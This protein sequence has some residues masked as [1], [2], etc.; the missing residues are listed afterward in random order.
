MFLD[1]FFLAPYHGKGCCDG[2]CGH[3]KNCAKTEILNRESL[4]ME[5]TTIGTHVALATWAWEKYEGENAKTADR[6]TDEY[7]FYVNIGRGFK[8]VADGFAMSN[9]GI[10][11][12]KPL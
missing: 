10:I 1:L 5:R 7:V 8:N 2:V 12:N 9:D 4:V 11:K 6:D 3:L